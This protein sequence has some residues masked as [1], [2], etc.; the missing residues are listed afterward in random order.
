L[1]DEQVRNTLA[2]IED[3]MRF[4]LRMHELIPREMSQYRTADGRVHFIAPKLFEASLCI[5]GATMEDGWFFDDVEFLFQVGGDV[6]G[7]QG[8][9]T[10]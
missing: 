6:S 3:V 1:N 2:D 8:S 10:E 7:M 9:S 5:K 4:R